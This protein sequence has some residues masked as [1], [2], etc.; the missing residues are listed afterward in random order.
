MYMY[1]FFSK[2][3]LRLVLSVLIAVGIC[4]TFTVLLI[5]GRTEE[6]LEFSVL[7]QERLT[8]E[9]LVELVQQTID[10]VYDHFNM[11]GNM[12]DIQN[13]LK[14]LD[15]NRHQKLEGV[16]LIQSLSEETRAAGEDVNNLLDSANRTL[17]TISTLT[18]L[19]KSGTTIASTNRESIGWNWKDSP[20]YL[21][22]MSGKSFL[23]GPTMSVNGGEPVFIL[24]IPVWRENSVV[25]ILF[26]NFSLSAVSKFIVKGISKNFHGQVIVMNND[27][28]V[29]LHPDTSQVLTNIFTDNSIMQI[30]QK[31]DQGNLT[32][33]LEG[34]MYLASFERLHKV[35][36]Q[37][38]SSLNRI[39]PDWIVMISVPYNEMVTATNRLKKNSLMVIAISM[40][41]ITSVIIFIILR[42]TYALHRV[43]HYAEAIAE[44]DLD[45]D[46]VVIKSHDEIGLLA[47]ALHKMV[48]TL[49]ENERT[50]HIQTK[51]V[52][53]TRDELRLKMEEIASYKD[54][55]EEM[56]ASR[57][58]DLVQAKDAAQ[59]AMQAK[60]NFL[61]RMSHEIRTPL[62][63]V[64]GLSYLCLQ[65]NMNEKQR[66]TVTKIH[67]AGTSLLR[68]VDNVLD[69]SQAE[70]GHICL[71]RTPFKL[72]I[73]LIEIFDLVKEKSKAKKL[74][75][76]FNVEQ[77]VPLNLRG[78]PQRLRQ[79]LVNL[80][81]NAIKFT[82]EGEIRLDVCLAPSSEVARLKK[83]LPQSEC[84]LMFCV[85][86]T[87][88]GLDPDQQKFL[89]NA[90]Y[91]VDESNTRENNGTG[92]GL[93][94]CKQL[95]ELYSGRCWVESALGV[96]SSFF[97]TAKL[98]MAVA[99]EMLDF[100]SMHEQSYQIEDTIK[101]EIAQDPEY[102]IMPQ[103]LGKHILLVEDNE[104]N[105]E[106]AGELLQV[107]GMTV[108]YANNGLEALKALQITSN[109]VPEPC[110]FD[111][112]LMDIQMPVMDGL[113][114]TRR[115]RQ[116]YGAETLPIL[117]M[118]AHAA[119][120][121]QVKSFEAGMNGHLT[122]PIDPEALRNELIKWLNRTIK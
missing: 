101:E 86:D 23:E 84:F 34:M 3:G 11:L 59:A 49:R 114:A 10:S 97:F 116:Y 44:G 106:I 76:N 62:N 51:E 85:R 87:G 7:N 82:H 113:E 58:Q 74:C 107:S 67:T 100:L 91:M 105:R 75:V 96:G 28:I 36:I 37:G 52:E 55:L 63:A 120:E 54:S 16:T 70:T 81:S 25:G 79:I 88:I 65:M 61:A 109:H 4:L 66:D 98:E 29:L 5:F 50:A 110:L 17:N 111:L 12:P 2:L 1:T 30:V 19:D 71:A 68:M 27:G 80:F 83:P 64:I 45:I 103:I 40:L 14:K 20:L 102:K 47:N 24:G 33:T 73:L 31:K 15:E 41:T 9:S 121:D 89:Y 48:M 77:D 99:T 118:T 117:A 69:F 53:A 72:D 95:V 115:I 43:I 92:L 46:F 39:I 119:G 42:L 108:T 122:K 93:P 90:F 8:T 26:G 94:I 60:S 38:V 56:V 18:L 112:V 22:V 78:D 6:A 21:R 13:Y 57:T 32:Y 35:D 104:I